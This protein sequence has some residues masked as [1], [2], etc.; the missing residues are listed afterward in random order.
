MLD[1]TVETLLDEQINKELYP[2]TFIL[3][4]LYIMQ[5]RAGWFCKLV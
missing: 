3:I 2:L 5:N 1:K 4:F